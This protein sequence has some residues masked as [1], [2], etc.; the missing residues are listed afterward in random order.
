MTLMLSTLAAPYSVVAFCQ[1]MEELFYRRA[2]IRRKGRGENTY[3]DGV[4]VEE[5]GQKTVLVSLVGNGNGDLV[6][7]RHLDCCVCC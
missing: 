3:V 1:L 5:Q 6:V 4:R 2:S 7:V